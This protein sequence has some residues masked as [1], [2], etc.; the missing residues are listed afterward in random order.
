ML[1]R[2]FWKGKKVFV[3][4]H[5]GF[6]GS[7][8]SFWLSMLGAEVT[9]YALKPPT[10]P[11]FFKLCRIDK[12]VNSIIGDITDLKS[13]KKLIISKKPE[14][15]IHMAAQ[16]LVRESY[17][18]P[19]NTYITNVMGLVNMFEAVRAGKN[20]RAVINVTTDKCYE[21]N[22][23][24]KPFKENAPLGGF[25]PY[26]NSKAC[27][28]LIT[29]SYRNSFFNPDN[30]KKHGIAI[31]TARA[32]NVIGGGDWAKDRLIPDF[33]RS[34]LNKEVVYIRNPKA[35][36]PWQHV[37]DPLNGYLMLAENLYK[38]GPKYGEAW[39]FGPDI[40]ESRDVEWIVRKLCKKW[41]NGANYKI[42]RGKHPHEAPYLRLDCMKAKIKLGWAPKWGL[43]T[44]LNKIVDW[45]KVYANNKDLR[46]ISY[47]QINEFMES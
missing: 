32:G 46:K 16:S 42:D 31:A 25:D 29:S 21:N 10:N 13:L 39:N 37:L 12:I 44:S 24:N 20:I 14:I 41:G 45:T 47:L 26:S 2:K 7:W 8:L 3:T 23:S 4:G 15:V 28:E 30:Y 38:F 18:D 11:S 22:Y 27:S 43:E 6:K 5:T 40:N 34:I 19:I 35:I 33:V 1:R 17:L 36:R 9:G